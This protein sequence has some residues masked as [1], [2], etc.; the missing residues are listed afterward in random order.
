M[1]AVVMVVLAVAPVPAATV[2][3]NALIPQLPV[4]TRQ[5]SRQNPSSLSD[6]GSGLHGEQSRDGRGKWEEEAGDG[7]AA[8]FHGVFSEA[9][10]LESS[11]NKG[12]RT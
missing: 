6:S 1:S 12:G 11:G 10:F 5:C 9:L 8:E 2:L 3:Q 4:V 7:E